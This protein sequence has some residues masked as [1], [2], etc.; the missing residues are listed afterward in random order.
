MAG[1]GAQRV[2]DPGALWDS[3]LLAKISNS[4]T[5]TL[6]GVVLCAVMTLFLAAFSIDAFGRPDFGAG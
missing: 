1:Y 4:L 5:T 6:M 2:N 3:A